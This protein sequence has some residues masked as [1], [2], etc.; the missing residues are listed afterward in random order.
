V[1][2]SLDCRKNGEN[3]MNNFNPDNLTDL[4]EVITIKVTSSI[5][6]YTDDERDLVIISSSSSNNAYCGYFKL[7]LEKLLFNAG[8]EVYS[9]TENSTTIANTHEATVRKFLRSTSIM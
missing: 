6:I 7:S 8:F 4:E 1:S 2:V 9:E 3:L 5:I